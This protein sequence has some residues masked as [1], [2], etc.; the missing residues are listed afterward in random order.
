MYRFFERDMDRR[1]QERH[2]LELELRA[3]LA[4]NQFE[5]FYQPLV[6]LATNR[7]SGFEALMRWHH[8]TRGLVDAHEFILLTEEM[9]L[10]AQLGQWA[11]Q[12]ACMEAAAW[13]DDVRVAVNLSPAQLNCRSLMDCVTKSLLDAHL[14]AHRLELEITEA[15]LLHHGEEIA[16]VLE[17]LRDIGVR[18]AMDNS[19]TGY[20]SLRHLHGFLLDKIKI[21]RSFIG[22]LPYDRDAAAVVRAITTLGVSLR[23]P[24][25]A[26]GVERE[27]QLAHLRKEGCT[28]AQ[29]FVFSAPRPASEIS[30]LL[31]RFHLGAPQAA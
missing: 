7:I 1:L 2:R 16:G 30:G 20:N 24:T 3:A 23:M 5:L 26:E 10:M 31:E 13:P 8:P 6:D 9:G 21:D 22:D 4:N 29:G 25:T 17:A 15:A 14:P 12:Q 11:L 19:G 28:E 18:I 27:E